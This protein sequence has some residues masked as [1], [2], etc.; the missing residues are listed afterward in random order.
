MLFYPAGTPSTHKTKKRDILTIP[1]LTRN[2]RQTARRTEKRMLCAHAH[3]LGTA[4]LLQAYA[5]SETAI[6]RTLYSGFPPA[7]KPTVLPPSLIG[8]SSFFTMHLAA[9]AAESSCRHLHTAWDL[10]PCTANEDLVPA[11]FKCP[12]HACTCLR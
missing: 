6:A 3:V 2:L 9:A 4:A 8:S 11:G 12:L 7:C 1:S 5:Y 10:G